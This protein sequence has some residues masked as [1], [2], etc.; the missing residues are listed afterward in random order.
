MAKL[1]RAVVRKIINSFTKPNHLLSEIQCSYLELK[2]KIGQKPIIF[3]DWARNLY[4]QYPNDNIRYNWKRK[5][6]TDAKHIV[7]YIFDNVK[8]GWICVDIGANIGAV[9]IPLW[10]K[11]GSTGSVYSVEP[12]PSNIDKIKSNLKLNNFPRD[13]VV[14]I[15]ISDKKGV[16]PLRIYPDFNGWQTFGN[17]SFAKEYKSYVI[18]VPVISFEEF[19]ETCKIKSVDFVKIDVEGAEI[20]VLNGMRSF[21][22]E[23]SIG[24]LVFEVNHLMLEGMNSNVSDLFSFWE[25]FD[26][27]LWRLADDGTLVAIEE[28][29]PNN[30][31]GDCIAFP[32]KLNK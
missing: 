15:A 11:V 29:W 7:R 28:T 2:L 13:S 3:T 4:W 30:I 32:R 26:Y 5:S 24:S 8:R 6:V 23:K 19:M 14:N 10:S 25:E 21:L 9:S 17:P 16:M 22:S 20:L 27:E 1:C 12:D 31:I 18:E